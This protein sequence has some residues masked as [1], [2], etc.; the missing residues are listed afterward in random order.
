MEQVITRDDFGGSHGQMRVDE[1]NLTEAERN[2]VSW[3]AAD[4][5][6][7]NRHPL[8]QFI[9]L[10]RDDLEAAIKSDPGIPA[11][12]ESVLLRILARPLP[13]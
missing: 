9:T 3:L 4:V 7:R 1:T 6:R 5:A 2:L 8:E 13:Q 10:L 11:R 12:S